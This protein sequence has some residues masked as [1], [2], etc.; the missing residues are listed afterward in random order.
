M[1]S[2][3]IIFLRNEVYENEIRTPLI[4]SDIKILINNNFTVFVESCPFRIYADE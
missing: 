2:N 4:P 1:S 3:L